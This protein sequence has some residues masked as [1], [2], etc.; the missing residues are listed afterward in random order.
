MS[1]VEIGKIFAIDDLCV[2]I[3]KT[4]PQWIVIHAIGRA[5][6]TGWSR[7][8]LAKHVHITPPADGVQ[9]LEFNAQMPEPN[10][11]VLNVLSPI[12]AHAEFANV[13]IA[14]YWGP[15]VPLKGVRVRAVSN[16]KAVEVLPRDDVIAVRGQMGQGT[17]A[18]YVGEANQDD[19]PSFEEDIRPLFRPRDIN[20]MRNIAGFDLSQF[21]DVKANADRIFE[22]LQVNMPCDGLWPAED[23]AK[24][25]AWKDGGMPA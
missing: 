24:F 13:D 11:P 4:N 2:Y 12:S 25:K 15:G 14:N 16:E 19:V 9:A 21:E 7:G 17:T 3:T 10:T 5:A 22:R 20:V 1:T 23:L 8:L 18:S 6:T